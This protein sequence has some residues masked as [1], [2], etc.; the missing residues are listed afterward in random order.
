MEI[1]IRPNKKN[2]IIISL[3]II[4]FC[5]IILFLIKNKQNSLK[6]KKYSISYPNID[7]PFIQEGSVPGIER[8]I[9]YPN[10]TD[11]QN[12]TK[13]ANIYEY[14]GENTI[15]ADL[16]NKI[17]VNNS[18]TDIKRGNDIKK[19]NYLIAN[20]FSSSLSVFPD[21]GELSILNIITNYNNKFAGDENQSDYEETARTYMRAFGIDQENYI[22]S[23]YKYFSTQKDN[24]ELKLVNDPKNANLVEMIFTYA[25]DGIKI[26]DSELNVN[27]NNVKITMTPNME[28]TKF[29]YQKSKQVGNK[30]EE[31]KLINEEEVQ[32]A[33]IKGEASLINQTGIINETPAGYE[34]KGIDL[35]YKEDGN[36]L[37]PVYLIKVDIITNVGISGVG[38]M[39]LEAIK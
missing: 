27:S 33:V 36:L 39:V 26:V 30:V 16:I 3:I 15:D 31:V 19:G 12:Y 13:K 21:Y 23:S 7:I 14:N 8:S 18:L 32:K 25:V 9:I 38:T 1:N 5:L 35:V 37:I 4:F 2:I 6:E 29:E 34:V 28:I 22:F 24:Y 10:N 11:I 20:G 17:I